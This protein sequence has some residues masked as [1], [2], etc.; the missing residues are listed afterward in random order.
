VLGAADVELQPDFAPAA[1]AFTQRE[2][3]LGRQLKR[4]LGKGQTVLAQDLDN[5]MQVLRLKHAMRAAD[6]L[7]EAE[8]DRVTMPR[9]G[10]PAS[11][12]Q[13]AALPLGARLARDMQAGQVLQIADLA[14]TQEILVASANLTAGQPLNAALFKLEP[15][16]QDKLT[17]SHLFSTAGL[18][19]QELSRALRAGEALRSTDLRPA[20]LIKKGELVRFS[21]GKGPDFQVSVRLEALQDGRLGEQI[22]FRNNESGRTLSGVVSGQ[23]AAQGL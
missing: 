23:N 2:P 13:G 19:G 8:I 20:L 9:Q 6:L 14:E 15:I 11:A 1:G 7:T 16:S 5:A 22:K 4:T 21:V 3:V 12:W 18:E 17:R 10:A